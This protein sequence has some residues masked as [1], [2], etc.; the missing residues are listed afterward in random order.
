M[1]RRK[2][3]PGSIHRQNIASTAQ[4]LF[5]QK[6]I[7]GTS[8]NEIAQC[9]GYSKATLYVYFKNKEELVGFLVLESMEKL[10]T[11]IF[12]ALKNSNQTKRRNQHRLYSHG[13]SSGRNGNLQS[14]RKD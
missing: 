2:K 10:Y 9:S 13:F 7:E 4:E 8:M 11:H 1:G 12:D 5:M 3:E 14:R 6:G